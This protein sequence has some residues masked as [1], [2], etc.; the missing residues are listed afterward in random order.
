MKTLA[1]F[2]NYLL[3]QLPG[4]MPDLLDLE[5]REVIREYVGTTRCWSEQLPALEADGARV[6]FPLYASTA[7]AEVIGLTEM[8]EGDELVWARVEPEISSNRHRDIPRLRA[9]QVP[10][11]LSMDYTQV[12]FERAP[13]QTVLLTGWIRPS[14]AMT[15]YPDFLLSDHL[16]GIR[17]G[18]LARMLAM[19]GKPWSD[20][21]RAAAFEQDYQTVLGVRSTIASRGNVRGPI[22]SR[23]AP[24]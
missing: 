15:A 13:T 16:E 7:R 21:A 23:K 18:T 1:D 4:C 2:Y 19:R 12:T 17:K 5:L 20:D 6:T 8:R 14:R 22:R 3:P 10:F 9:Y 24:L 11:V